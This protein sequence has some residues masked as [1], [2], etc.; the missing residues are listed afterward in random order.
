LFFVIFHI[1]TGK[2]FPR[3]QQEWGLLV[4]GERGQPQ[5]LYSTPL[6]LCSFKYVKSCTASP[7]KE[8]EQTLFLLR[9]HELHISLLLEENSN[10][11]EASSLL[12]AR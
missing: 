8:D 3:G 5:P 9:G 11:K 6:N 12:G 1:F 4:F 10:I 2:N 7:F